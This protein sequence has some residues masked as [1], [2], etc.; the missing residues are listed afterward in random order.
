MRKQGFKP[1][2]AEARFLIGTQHWHKPEWAPE[3]ITKLKRGCMKK[4]KKRNRDLLL[5]VFISHSITTTNY[6]AWSIFRI[7]QI[8]RIYFERQNRSYWFPASLP[9]LST[10]NLKTQ[11]TDA[12]THI[13]WNNGGSLESILFCSITE[14]DLHTALPHYPFNP[15]GIWEYF[16]LNGWY[17]LGLPVGSGIKK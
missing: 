8:A 11:H 6:K 4:E 14:T 17:R 15:S 9:C 12:H 5:T 1:G 2:K 7:W 3:I 10:R 16:W 13:H